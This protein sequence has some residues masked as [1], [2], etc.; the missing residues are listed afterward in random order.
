MKLGFFV[1]TQY[2]SH[3]PM[4]QKIRENLEQVRAAR[5]AGFD[6]V[7]AGQHYL[8]SPYLMPATFPFLARLCAEAGE[9]QVAATVILLPL[10]NPVEIAEM[11][12]TMDGICDGRFIFGIGLGYREEE[13]SAFGIQRKDRV[14]RLLEALEIMKLLWTEDEVEFEGTFYRVPRIK[15]TCRTT[16]KPYPPIWV[17]ANNDVAIRRA[18][19][20]GYPWIVN[21]HATVSL[22]EKQLNLYV[23]ALAESGKVSPSDMP[24]MREMYVGEDREQALQESGPYLA[25]KYQAYAEWGQDKALPGDESFSVPFEELSKDRFLIGTPDDIVSEIGRYQERLGVNYMIFR[26]QWPG[27][28]HGR[29]MKQLELM[30]KHVIP[31]IKGQKVGTV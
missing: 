29:V 24:M 9:M 17:A 4:D 27:M 19:R 5:D 12:A 25:S 15:S 7:C 6:L 8:S 21:P 2:M 28:E 14:P 1:S 10:H 11:V 13:Y 3:E 22:V 31:Q 16:Q 20:L 23:R 18:A 26:M 30:A